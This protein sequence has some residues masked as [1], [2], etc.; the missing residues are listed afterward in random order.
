MKIGESAEF[1]VEATGDGLIYQWQYSNSNGKYWYDSG[2]TGATTA[3]LT[4]PALKKRDGQVYRCLVKD[5][6]GNELYSEAAVLTL[7][8]ETTITI[9]AQPESQTAGKGSNAVFT[10]KAE[11]DGL[12]YQWQYSTSGKYWFDSGM[13]GAA[14]ASLTVPVIEKRNGQQYR[15]VVKDAN[16]NEVISEV[17]VLT[18]GEAF[19]IVVQPESQTVVVGE[20]ATFTVEAEG[21]GLSYQWQYSKNGIYWFD[22]GMEGADTKSLTVEA[23]AKRAGQQYR[24]VITDTNGSKVTSE[25][26]VLN[27]K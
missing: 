1:V 16:G 12:I 21:D 14:T 10:I 15:C 3:S 20:T 2:M 23:L 26:A 17:A 5:S 9:I 6:Y 25:V 8:E 18:L 19:Q 11:G 27:I 7:Y 13:E 22:S 4:V 24:C